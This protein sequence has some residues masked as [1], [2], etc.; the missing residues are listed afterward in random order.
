MTFLYSALCFRKI[1]KFVEPIFVV[2]L[3]FDLA[4]VMSSSI[5]SEKLTCFWYLVENLWLSLTVIKSLSVNR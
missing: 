1:V 5:D 3:S 4:S 2:V